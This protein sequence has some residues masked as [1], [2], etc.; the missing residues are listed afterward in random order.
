[1]GVSTSFHYI[2]PQ[3][4]GQEGRDRFAQSA[5]KVG[6]GLCF[7]GRALQSRKVTFLTDSQACDN[8]HHLNLFWL[9]FCSKITL[10]FSRP[11]S[12]PIMEQHPALR[13]GCFPSRSGFTFAAL[14]PPPHP[15]APGGGF[16][17]GRFA[18]TRLTLTLLV[19]P[20]HLPAPH[21]ALPPSPATRAYKGK[22]G[23]GRF[24]PPNPLFFLCRGERI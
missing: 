3:G 12:K 24:A 9:V 1:M 11:S 10:Y 20:A 6:G 15:R 4:W 13:A 23:W 18:L 19:R 22:E 21:S 14:A 5:H 17:C 8:M 2:Y 16:P 7:A